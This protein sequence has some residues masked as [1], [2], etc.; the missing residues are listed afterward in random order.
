[1]STPLDIEDAYTLSPMQ[2]GM[3][4]ESLLAPR[5]GTYVQQM[6][7][8][9]VGP[10]DERRLARAWALVTRR[11]TALRTAFVWKEVDVPHQI[12]ARE[13]DVPLATLDWSTRG[14]ARVHDLRELMRDERV[15]GFD[16]AHAP[17]Q[18]LLLVRLDRERHALVWTYHHLL[19]DNWSEVQVLREVAAIYARLAAHGDDEL[20]PALAYRRYV[21]W[22]KRQD[23][24]RAEGFWRATLAG[25]RAPTPIP[26]LAGTSS[27]PR[28]EEGLAEREVALC[29]ATTD[30]LRALARAARV[31]QSSIVQA[32]WALVL[33]SAA[34]CDDVVFGIVVRT[35]C[36]EVIDARNAACGLFIN[37]LP[38]RVRVCPEARLRDWL[39]EVQGC[40]VAAREHE[41]ASLAQIR[42]WSEVARDRPVFESFV[43]AQSHTAEA[44]SGLRFDDLE[45]CE[46]RYVQQ[47]NYPVMVTEVAGSPLRVRLTYDFRRLEPAA[48]D[49]LLH[50]L[51]RILDRAAASHDA[52][53][54][55]VS[56]GHVLDA[57]EGLALRLVASGA[58]RPAGRARERLAATRRRPV[59]LLAEGAP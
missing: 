24:A 14:A 35:G 8:V 15:A 55:D 50:A 42:A 20:R 7:A 29:A 19:L 31:T 18:R 25:F 17:L 58:E 49:H 56:V 22:L 52:R 40:A 37:T 59:T 28:S 46:P 16:A 27:T 9:L 57:A 5:A 3:L 48:A 45:L 21:A 36:P 30:A 6:R 38:L 23:A 53:G 51:T 39:R 11:H 33:A 10:L 47:S 2:E 12:V 44:M 41:S 13:V 43:V 1:M 26:C 32:A 4:F 34:R 54:S